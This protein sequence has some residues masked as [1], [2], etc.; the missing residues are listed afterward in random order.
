MSIDKR[1]DKTAFVCD[2]CSARFEAEDT[3]NNRSELHTRFGLLPRGWVG[4]CASGAAANGTPHARSAR[5]TIG[6]YGIGNRG[7]ILD[8]LDFVFFDCAA[9]T[10]V[11]VAV[12]QQ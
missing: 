1:G 10:F 2:V 8:V 5:P 6:N 12:I 11:S 9:T 4:A 7:R 3:I